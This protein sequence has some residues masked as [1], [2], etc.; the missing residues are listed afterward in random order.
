MAGAMGVEIRITGKLPSSRAK[1]WRFTK[2]YIK[3]TG[4]VSDFL[5]DHAIE[6]VTLKTG[7]VG[8]QVSIM[9]PDTPLPDK[10]IYIDNTLE[11]KVEDLIKSSKSEKVEIDLDEE[12]LNG[13]I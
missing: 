4:Y 5:V 3:K 6:S 10:I 8:I 2:G 12:V 11:K 13:E 1:S 9:L 7:V